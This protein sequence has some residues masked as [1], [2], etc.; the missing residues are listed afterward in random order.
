M[1]PKTDRDLMRHESA[2][3]SRRLSPDG[4]RIENRANSPLSDVGEQLTPCVIG[5]N[6]KLCRD[7][8]RPPHSTLSR[9][10]RGFPHPSLDGRGKREG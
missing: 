10:G 2:L 8:A 9:Q 7:P 6:L 4:A 1:K 5:I 3:R